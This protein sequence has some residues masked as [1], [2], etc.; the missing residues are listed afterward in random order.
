MGVAV[1]WL[2]FLLHCGQ[3][4][5]VRG[6]KVKGAVGGGRWKGGNQSDARLSARGHN[7]LALAVRR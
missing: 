1:L 4:I 5:K 6:V 2:P 3:Q 7:L